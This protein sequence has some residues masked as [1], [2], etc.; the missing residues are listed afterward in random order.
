[1]KSMSLCAAAAAAALAGT[2]SAG[3]VVD[4]LY[5][6]IFGANYG[7]QIFRVASDLSGQGLSPA[8]GR[9][10]PEGM[11]FYNGDLYVTGDGS[12]A[13]TNGY[14]A[15]YVG[16]NLASTPVATRFTATVNGTSFAGYGPEGIAVNTRRAAG[17]LGAATGSFVGIDSVV[18]PVGTRILATMPAAGGVVTNNLTG[19]QLNYDDIT[20]VPGAAADG[21]EDRFAVIFSTTIN[22]LPAIRLSW[23]SASTGLPTGV[24]DFDLV[25]QDKG[26][27]YLPADKANLFLPG[28]NQ[29]VLLVSNGPG[30]GLD[31][32]L[33]MY[34]LTGTLLSSAVLSGLNF[35]SSEA[36]AFD[37][38][39]NRL[40]IGDENAASSNIAVL[41]IPAPGAAVLAGAAGL[42][43]GRRRR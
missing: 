18:S 35:S 26:L 9:L 3:V 2:A 33:R 27:L 5:T 38:A 32:G 37:P 15:K 36:L 6:N 22:T 14:M 34:S 39:T 11:A 19:A 8:A 20:F 16:G 23:L 40:Y 31:N 43:A 29:P 41:T 42:L 4:N 1:M 28:V 10:E 24:G 21:S 13:E 7:I 30:N 25:D 12:T 17:Q